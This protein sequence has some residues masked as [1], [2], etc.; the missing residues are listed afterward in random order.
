[1][2]TPT[3]SDYTQSVMPSYALQLCSYP[4]HTAATFNVYK[5]TEVGACEGWWIIFCKKL[6]LTTKQEDSL[7]LFWKRKFVKLTIDESVLSSSSVKVLLS[8][9]T[10]KQKNFK[11]YFKTKWFNI[12]QKV[13]LEK[14]TLK[15]LSCFEDWWWSWYI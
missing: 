8:Q 3:Q 15:E 11:K 1:M 5:T 14:W 4:R 7:N 9:I 2:P 10:L 12:C 6:C 13:H